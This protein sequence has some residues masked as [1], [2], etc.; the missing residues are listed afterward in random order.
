[1]RFIAFLTALS[2]ALPACQP[3][4]APETVVR[5]WQSHIDRNEFQQAMALSTPRTIELLSWM[6]ALLSEM[7]AE[8]AIT[9]TEFLDLNCTEKGNTAICHYALEDDGTRYRDSFLLVRSK[10]KWLVDLPE[11]PAYTEDDLEP[12]FEL[13][14]QDSTNLE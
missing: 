12:L 7:D 10:G 14:I 1:M 6:E 8:S 2:V 9:H 13:L 5:K 4:D 11:E 3:A